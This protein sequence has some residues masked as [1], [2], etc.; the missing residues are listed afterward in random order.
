LVVSQ[1]G[2]L[3]VSDVEEAPQLSQLSTAG[4]L[5]VQSSPKQRIR[6]DQTVRMIHPKTGA[7]Q[8]FAS[9]NGFGTGV[10]RSMANRV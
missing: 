4:A 7:T 2:C 6:R 1:L 9:P 5:I 8:T 3:D 10:R